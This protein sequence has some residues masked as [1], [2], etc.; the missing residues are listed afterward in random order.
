MIGCSLGCLVRESWPSPWSFQDGSGPGLMSQG[1]RTVQR[2]DSCVASL[3][4]L[5]VTL[6]VGV[7]IDIPLASLFVQ[8]ALLCG[9]VIVFVDFRIG[10]RTSGAALF[11]GYG[12][13]L[14]H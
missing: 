10:S 7:L 6:V 9:P 2:S 13:E 1:H 8:V 5:L 3:S 14:A 12:W 11:R 4:I